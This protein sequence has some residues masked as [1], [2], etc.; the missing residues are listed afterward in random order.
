MKLIN[1]LDEYRML[2][3]K[4][5]L[6]EFGTPDTCVPCKMTE[7]N[8]K[9][10]EQDGNFNLTFYSCYDINV[11]TSLGYSKIPVVKLVTPQ[12]VV[13]LKDASISMDEDELVDWI[14]EN[15]GE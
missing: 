6:I 8:L 15:V 9:K 7:D 13:E 3:D 11:I 5:Y 4:S 14:S 10:I 12:K 1:T 2:N